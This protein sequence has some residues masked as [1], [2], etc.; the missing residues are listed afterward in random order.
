MFSLNGYFMGKD[1]PPTF[2]VVICTYND[3]EYLSY[4]IDSVMNQSMRNWDL[5]I[6]DDASTD[7]TGEILEPWKSNPKVHIISLP[8]NQGKAT[9]LNTAL[10]AIK[11]TWL[12]ELDA[13]DWLARSALEFLDRVLEPEAVA[14]YGNYAE[15]REHFR[16][17]ELT[18]TKVV[19]GMPTF[20]ALNY[21]ESAYPLSPRI[22]RAD[23][24]KKIGGWHTKDIYQSR[25]YEDVY[26]LCALSKQGK[27]VHLNELLY[28]RRLRSGSVSTAG[29]KEK[30]QKWV[31]WVKKELFM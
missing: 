7:N 11:G 8:Y 14:Y 17:K 2:S 4:A 6:V 20:H 15:W 10:Q 3:A 21:L 18:F 26:I 29:K 1:D 5:I 31:A 24:L 13:D 12:V 28:H 23:A 16:S 9:C 30:F 22:Y 25:L 19:K 27:V